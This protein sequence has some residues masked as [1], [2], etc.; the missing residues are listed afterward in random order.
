MFWFRGQ[1]LSPLIDA[2]LTWDDFAN[3]RGDDRDATIAHAVER[4]F[5]FVAAYAGFKWAVLPR[6]LSLSEHS[7]DECRE[8]VQSSG[9]FDAHYYLILNPDVAHTGQDPLE[10]FLK[11][12]YREGR[13]P[14]DFFDLSYYSQFLE[15]AA[16]SE[17]INPLV[18][19]ILEGRTL[20]LLPRA[21]RV[22]ASTDASAVRNLVAEDFASFGGERTGENTQHDMQVIE[23]SGLFDAG[24]YLLA[25]PD[26]ASTGD[27]PL[28]HYVLH[29]ASEGRK[30]NPLFDGSWYLGQ[31]RDVAADGANPLAH[32]VTHGFREGRF[33]NPMFDSRWYLI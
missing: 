6:R 29:G 1:A 28:L 12:G 10:H 15:R 27:E 30:P 21:F 14:S 8:V 31:Y 4:S 25:Y 24:W 23:E 3:S 11:W 18:H 17:H 33:P 16:V 13:N 2:G 9:F 5:L 20:G 7:L 32:Y 26:V 19:Y 22:Q